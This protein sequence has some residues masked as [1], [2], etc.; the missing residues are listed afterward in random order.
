[1]SSDSILEIISFVQLKNVQE[2]SFSKQ[3][4]EETKTLWVLC[5]WNLVLKVWFLDS[6][7]I[8]WDLRTTTFR[9]Y[10]LN[11]NHFTWGIHIT[12][13]FKKCYR[14][15]HLDHISKSKYYPLKLQHFFHCFPSQKI[16]YFQWTLAGNLRIIPEAL[17]LDLLHQSSHPI[18]KDPASKDLLSSSVN[19]NQAMRI[20]N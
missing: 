20:E 9:L 6:I 1:M 14:F 2:G 7:R 3:T 12:L 11:E 17:S 4:F 8:T 19:V 16:A 10:L 5:S 18:S 15:L 13:K